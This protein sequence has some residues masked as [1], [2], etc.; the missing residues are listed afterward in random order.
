MNAFRLFVFLPAL[1][2]AGFLFISTPIPVQAQEPTTAEI[3]SAVNNP[4][5]KEYG[6]AGYPKITVYVWGNADTGVWRVEEKTDLLEFVSVVSRIRMANRDPDRRQIET[7]RIYREQTPQSDDDPFFEKRVETLFSSRD[8][9]PSLKEGDILVLES[10]AKNRFTWRD[11][12][13]VTGTVAA[14]VNTYL[15]LD[16][17]GDE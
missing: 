10:R 2:V 8:N 6:R 12:A 9:Y 15:L 1:F 3:L 7:L 4:T 17:L 11:I 5:V 16:R 14:V 13:R